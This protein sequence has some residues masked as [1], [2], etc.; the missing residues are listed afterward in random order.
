MAAFLS[1]D[2]KLQFFDN[3]GQP[4]VGGR[5]YTF[6]AGSSTPAVTYTS[7]SGTTLNTNPIILDTRGEASVWLGSFPY[8]FRLT[9]SNNVVIWTV[10]N[11]GTQDV[12]AM[13]AKPSGSSLIGYQAP[14]EGWVARTVQS[15][16][17]ETVSVKDFGA[18]GDGVSNDTQAFVSALQAGA[19]A[20]VYVPPGQYLCSP[21]VIPNGTCLF[22]DSSNSCVIIASSAIADLSPL[23]S[24]EDTTGPTISDSGI[25]L[26]GLTFTG[27]NISSPSRTAGLVE[28]TYARDIVITS[29]AFHYSQ[30]RAVSFMSCLHV[31]NTSC[32][33]ANC[34]T[35]TVDSSVVNVGKVAVTEPA[36]PILSYDISFSECSFNDNLNTCLHLD[37]GNVS[38][39]NNVFYKNAG[40]AVSLVGNDSN[41]SSN[42][43]GE[44]GAVITTTTPSVTTGGIGISIAG[45]QHNITGNS[46]YNTSSDCIVIQDNAFMINITGN[47]MINPGRSV[48]GVQ[49][50]PQAACL[51]VYSG[52]SSVC[53]TGNLFE[54]V[55]GDSYTA[56]F[57]KGVGAAPLHTMISDCQILSPGW[58]AGTSIMVNG[59]IGSAPS[60]ND[61]TQIF[62]NNSGSFDLV[63]QG[64]HAPGVYYTGECVD[65]NSFFNAPTPPPPGLQ[66][67]HD[68]VV[69]STAVMPEVTTGTIFCTPFLIRQQ[70]VWTKI[71]VLLFSGSVRIGVY[72]IWNGLPTTLAFDAGVTA[73]IDT[74]AIVEIDIALP[75]YLT[76]GT[77]A[78]CCQSPTNTAASFVPFKLTGAG[79]NIFGISQY[80]TPPSGSS[81][82]FSYAAQCSF[83]YA[84]YPAIFPATSLTL[85][86][87]GTPL[88]TLRYGV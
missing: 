24:N 76:S 48:G 42:K 56:V 80:T 1:P 45:I 6:E 37:G 51:G 14:G 41:V 53:A 13:L 8:K 59:A 55:L 40:V 28:F 77:Y 15:K 3:S 60:Q 52:V 79:S 67:E 34:G 16:L 23:V 35:V 88:F 21:F 82:G 27:K 63:L 75:S 46:I 81:G 85:V 32:N 54:S 83:S 4:L 19:G 26:R 43:I 36:V 49:S 78:F 44:Q 68:G 39:N 74:P 64:G 47:S 17:R 84:A 7:A 70:Q 57:F 33:F 30:Y 66:P 65:I 62:R 58:L 5:I 9:D 12:L 11:V 10:D 50:F 73:A 18:T 2:P 31:D 38:V 61:P 71:G 86:S 22:G 72:R 20:S 69:R 29:C 87:T 25:T